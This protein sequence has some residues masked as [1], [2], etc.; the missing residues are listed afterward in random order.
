MCGP[1]LIKAYA[2]EDAL[3]QTWW[4]QGPAPRDP[5]V[6]AEPMWRC[7]CFTS[8]VPFRIVKVSRNPA[9]LRKR[10]EQVGRFYAETATTIR[11]TLHGR[12]DIIVKFVPTKGGGSSA[13]W[14]VLES[15]TQLAVATLDVSVDNHRVESRLD[16]H[17]SSKFFELDAS[18]ALLYLG[19]LCR[20][21][22][23]FVRPGVDVP[24]LVDESGCDID[25]DCE[26]A[27]RS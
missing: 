21:A 27:F 12:P 25:G 15:V 16:I 6:Y 26:G 8:L 10:A 23:T 4:A 9:T 20:Y 17:P 5:A 1:R 2:A 11:A 24:V 18:D 3:P 14:Q 19:L 13:R 22:F 7:P